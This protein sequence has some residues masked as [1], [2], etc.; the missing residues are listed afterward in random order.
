MSA[1]IASVSKLVGFMSVEEKAYASRCFSRSFSVAE[2][3]N[4]IKSIRS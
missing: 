4:L 2:T 3:A 1:F